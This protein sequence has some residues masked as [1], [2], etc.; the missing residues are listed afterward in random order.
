MA[1]VAV[2]RAVKASSSSG[3]TDRSNAGGDRA[4]EIH[5]EVCERAS[6]PSCNSFT[7]SYGSKQLDASLLLIPLVGFLPP[8]THAW[9]APSKRS[10]AS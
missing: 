5:D 4:T 7:Q 9:S 3:S 1:W 6:T 8:T 2:D 10:S